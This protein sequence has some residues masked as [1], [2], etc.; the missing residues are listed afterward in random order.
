MD[1]KLAGRVALITGS[2][3]GIGYAIAEGLAREGAAVIVNGR[4]Q[5]SV[6]RAVDRLKKARPQAAVEGIAADAASEA[7]AD[8]IFGRFPRVDV[9]VNNLGIYARKDF[10]DLHDDDWRHVFEVN[11]LSGVRFAR[12]YAPSMAQRG[13]GRIIFISSE[14]G[15]NIPTEM[16]HY[17]MTK[18]AQISISRGLAQALAGTGVTVNAV[19]PGPTR[20]DGMSEILRR[21][22]EKTGKTISD[23]ERSFFVSSRPTSLI[24]RYAEPEEVANMVAYIAGDVSACTTGAALRVEGGI[25]SGL[26]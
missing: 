16:V 8:Q 13:W 5:Q 17:G 26:G 14:S 25:V 4:S 9:L 23:L 1:L 11:V 15:L 22:S 12:L 21:E 19:L 20:T 2:T 3:S 6:D 10:L 24:R 7:G 18:T